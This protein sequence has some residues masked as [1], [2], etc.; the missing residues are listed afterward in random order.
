MKYTMDAFE[1]QKKKNGQKKIDV[2]KWKKM[3]R[4]WKWKQEVN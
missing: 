4:E 1:A 2:D 3:E